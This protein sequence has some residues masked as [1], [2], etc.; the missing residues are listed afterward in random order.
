MDSVPVKGSVPWAASWQAGLGTAV[1]CRGCRRNKVWQPLGVGQQ[2]QQQP[3][4]S[5]GLRL[6][7]VG[8][9][10]AGEVSLWVEGKQCKTQASMSR[11]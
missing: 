4:S 11:H 2:Q 3:A 5:E 10:A 6:A 7:G 1:G 9:S 8:L